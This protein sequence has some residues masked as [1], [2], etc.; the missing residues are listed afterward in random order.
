MTTYDVNNKSIQIEQNSD[1]FMT[2]SILGIKVI[3]FFKIFFWGVE[4]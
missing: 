4:D 2:D 3:Q 1:Q